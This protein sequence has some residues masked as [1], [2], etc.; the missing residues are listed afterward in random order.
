MQNELHHSTQRVWSSK[1]RSEECS[2][3]KSSFEVGSRKVGVW[4]DCLVRRSNCINYIM[5]WHKLSHLKRL[6]VKGILQTLS[7]RE[8]IQAIICPLQQTLETAPY[9]NWSN[10]GWTFYSYLQFIPP[11]PYSRMLV[12]VPKKPLE[13]DWSLESLPPDK[14][15]VSLLTDREPYTQKWQIFV[16]RNWKD[17][18]TDLRICQR[19]WNTQLWVSYNIPY[20]LFRK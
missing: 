2:A 10:L 3:T 14:T 16:G 20:T 18:A 4:L 11:H 17:H 8:F 13:V 5:T 9:L 12:V 1:N 19:K 15:Q 7:P 6:L